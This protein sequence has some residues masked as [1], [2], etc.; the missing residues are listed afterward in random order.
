MAVCALAAIALVDLFTVNRR[1]M[2][3]DNFTDPVVAGEEFEP[4][5]ADVAI[6]SDKG[7]FRVMD[8]DDFAGARSSYFHKTIGGYHA[9]K[10]TRYNDLI[11]HQISKGNPAVLDML[12]ARYV[13]S[14]GKAVRRPSARSIPAV[15][16]LSLLS[17]RESFPAL[18]R[19]R[20]A[21]R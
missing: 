7:H 19:H 4:T 16:Q 5:P 8:A 15:R 1:Y 11:E 21:I 17:S 10:L 6:L 3:S 18:L 2:D 20:Q 9:A 12:N 14:Q 13:I